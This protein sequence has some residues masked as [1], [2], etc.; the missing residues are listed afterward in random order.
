M[1]LATG[2]TG[3]PGSAVAGQLPE[4]T[5]A[6]DMAILARDP[7]KAGDLAGRGVCVCTGDYDD[8]ASLACAMDGVNRVVMV[9]S[10]QPQR[11]MQQHQDVI[12]AAVSVGEPGRGTGRWLRAD[13]GRLR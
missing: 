5:G 8:I 9:A 13:P 10:N 12:A 7:A 6:A 2:A 4:R 11:H 1:I 3:G